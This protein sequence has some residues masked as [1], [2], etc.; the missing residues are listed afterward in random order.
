[1]LLCTSKMVYILIQENQKQEKNRK[2]K[3]EEEHGLLLSFLCANF[4][5]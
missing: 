4:S 1:M 2:Q 3:R 5:D